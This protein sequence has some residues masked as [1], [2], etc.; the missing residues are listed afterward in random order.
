MKAPVM[1]STFIQV[2]GGV[3]RRVVTATALAFIG[4]LV[5]IS[6]ALLPPAIPFAIVGIAAI[7]LLWVVPELQ[8]LPYR[9]ARQTTPVFVIAFT[10][11]PVYYALIFPGVPWIQ[12][13]RVIQLAWL[14]PLLLIIAGS[15]DARHRI[16]SVLRSA[17]WLASCTV[18]YIAYTIVTL[19]TASYFYVSANSIMNGFINWYIP[20]FGVIILA[21]NVDSIHIFFR[22]CFI[23]VAINFVVG[24]V[25]FSLKHPFLIYALPAYMRAQIF[26]AS[27]IAADFL[28]YG[29]GMRDGTYRASST[30]TTA[31]SWGENCAMFIPF[32]FHF[33][34]H[35][36]TSGEK[37]F[38]ALCATLC[39][40][41]VALSG[42]RGAY[43]SM[44]AATVFYAICWSFRVNIQNRG[45][46]VGKIALAIFSMASAAAFLAIIFVGRLHRL[47][48]GGG[49]GQAST[50]SRA[51]EWAL[52]KPKILA[53]PILGY[54][55]GSAGDII[56]YPTS[57]GGFSVDG[58]YM[59]LLVDFGIP[60]CVLFFSTFL[61]AAALCMWIYIM[62]P[63]H[64]ANI[65]NA[66]GSSLVAFFLYRLTLSQTDSLVFAFM[67]IGLALAY[68][69][70]M[71]S[72][73]TTRDCLIEWQE[74][75]T[76]TVSVV[77][78]RS[79]SNPPRSRL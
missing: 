63:S 51:A 34:A 6:C 64:N 61:L 2:A 45:S 36:K 31:L 33:V 53:R 4:L 26:A 76:H 67:T 14:I 72:E 12:F 17:P 25:E 46:L 43:A 42:S 49:Q 9:W 71:R 30:F 5:G 78:P 47:I 56:H 40:G 66:L 58:Y 44:I 62:R 57:H 55:G 69:H 7:L 27:G 73:A 41:S 24:V 18:G 28:L 1:S 68:I 13:R 75:N 70:L 54:G 35:G 77:A 29:Q 39:V 21:R 50:D 8:R 38:G 3:G 22:V 23:G 20:M 60:G 59:N 19:P 65:G 79:Y 11:V 52:A 37:W 48:I 15:S 32:A 74:D 16:G 10:C